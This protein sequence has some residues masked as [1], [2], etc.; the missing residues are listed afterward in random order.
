LIVLIL[1][2]KVYKL[3]SFSLCNFLQ[4]PAISSL[5]RQNILLNTLFSNPLT[6]CPSLNVRHQVSHP[7]KT[8]AKTIAMYILIV[9]FPDS[10]REDR[11]FWIELYQALSE[12]NLLISSWNKFWFVTVVPKYLNFAKF[13][14]ALLVIFYVTAVFCILV[15]RYQHIISFSH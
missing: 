3:W 6:L 10:R 2:G 13:S 14:K 9:T 1:C 12:L 15:T 4:P 8:A 5:F 11:R 7:Y